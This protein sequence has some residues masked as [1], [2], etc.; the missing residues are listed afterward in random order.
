M[1]NHPFGEAHFKD[2]QTTP[3]SRLNR[4]RI[5]LLSRN[6]IFKTQGVLTELPFLLP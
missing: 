4:T 2:M 1:D 5:N 3:A 6:E